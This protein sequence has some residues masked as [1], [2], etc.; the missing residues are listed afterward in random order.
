MN[1]RPLWRAVAMILLGSVSVLRAQTRPGVPEPG[2]AAPAAAA[3]ST[4]P[5]GPLWPQF[6]GPRGDNRSPMTSSRK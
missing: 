5:A 1:Y 2:I 6:N 3:S 4:Q